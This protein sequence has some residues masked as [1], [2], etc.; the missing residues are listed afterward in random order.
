MPIQD[1]LANQANNESLSLVGEAYENLQ[2]ATEKKEEILQ[3]FN[4]TKTQERTAMQEEGE[5]ELGV[6]LYDA[7]TL[8]FENSIVFYNSNVVTVESPEN[9]VTGPQVVSFESYGVP[10]KNIQFKLKSTVTADQEGRTR[11]AQIVLE[12]I[13]DGSSLEEYFYPVTE[14]TPTDYIW[15]ELEKHVQ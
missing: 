4:K 5:S 12:V 11:I 13:K 10:Q 7:V 14:E 2:I 1:F 3:E 15:K 6:K 8:C 9:V